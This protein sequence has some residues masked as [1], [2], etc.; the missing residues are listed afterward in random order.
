MRT[1]LH[2]LLIAPAFFAASS[3]HARPG[4]PKFEFAW[5]CY[6]GE[7]PSGKNIVFVNKSPAPL[8]KRYDGRPQVCVTFVNTA[9]EDVRFEAEITANGEPVGRIGTAINC[10][11][12]H[13]GTLLA[14]FNSENCTASENFAGMLVTTH[15]VNGNRST[16]S[17]TAAFLQVAFDT[18]Y[19]FRFRARDASNDMVSENWTNWTCAHTIPEPA[20]PLK[21]KLLSAVVA[22]P[23]ASND[24]KTHRVVVAWGSPQ[25]LRA[26]QIGH[27]TLE[28]KAVDPKYNTIEKLIP[29]NKAYDS[30]ERSASIDL[31]PLMVQANN[32]APPEFLIKVCAHNASGSACSDTKSTS[33]TDPGDYRAPGD[34]N[35]DM[36][37][38]PKPPARTAPGNIGQTQAE[39]PYVDTGTTK[40]PKGSGIFARP[41][42]SS[43]VSDMMAAP[44]SAPPG[45][46]I[47]RSAEAK[48]SGATFTAT[49]N[50]ATAAGARYTMTLRQNGAEV[51]GSYTS[52]D[53]AVSGA[54]SGT[55]DG[56]TLTYRWQEG[57]S[58]GMGKFALSADGNAFQGWWNSSQTDP[59]AVSGA[60]NGTRQ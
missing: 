41:K 26:E 60:W 24:F 6:P 9:T 31:P 7:S 56:N 30:T 29:S 27:Y 43:N 20:K 47:L 57:P 42:S 52:S 44:S 25:T 50:T 10:L 59:N 1:I 53:S 18:E 16:G 5:E 45:G 34:F 4:T 28:A 38:K 33:V 23:A 3:A 39:S 35:P 14:L 36:V 13:A 17:Q 49:W 51:T 46:V 37:E 21:P 55:V 12:S 58:T 15:R 32:G 22:G 19:C 54:L 11:F 2:L 8:T 48:A 40:P